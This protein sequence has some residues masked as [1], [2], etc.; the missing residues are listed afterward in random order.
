M[1]NLQTETIMYAKSIIR[2]TLACIMLSLLIGIAAPAAVLAQPAAPAQRTFALSTICPESTANPGNNGC[3]LPEVNATQNTIKNI[4][5]IALGIAGAF[6]LMSMT[7]SGLKYIT[8]A[9]DPQ[10]TSEAKKGV[11]FALVGLMLAVS[12]EAIVAFVVHRGAI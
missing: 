5:Q 1:Y 12:A 8:A 2:K 7:S 4:I 10:K 6:A 3:Q 11:V 9:G